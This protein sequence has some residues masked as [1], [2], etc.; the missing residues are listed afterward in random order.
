VEF[1]GRDDQTL[2]EA[3]FIELPSKDV[4]RERR[5]STSQ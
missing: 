5:V 1:H 3:G 2:E 4:S